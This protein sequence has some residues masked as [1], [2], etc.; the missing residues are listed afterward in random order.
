MQIGAV[1][2]VQNV[3]RADVKGLRGQGREIGGMQ[4]VQRAQMLFTRQPL[5]LLRLGE[6]IGDGPDLPGADARGPCGG[7]LRGNA[8]RE[9]ALPKLN[10]GVGL[11]QT[12]ADSVH[13][14]CTSSWSEKPPVPPPRRRPNAAPARRWRY[15]REATWSVALPGG[16]SCASTVAGAASKTCLFNLRLLPLLDRRL[17]RLRASAPRA[18]DSA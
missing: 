11:K 9:Q 2:I 13:A 6:I 7:Q 15:K 17:A 10:L 4:R 12:S 14:C 3:H 16:T 5:G 1:G 18:G 8:Q